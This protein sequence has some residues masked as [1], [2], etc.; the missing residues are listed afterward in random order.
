LKK[1]FPSDF[2]PPSG[3]IAIPPP[4]NAPRYNVAA[5]LNYCKEHKKILKELTLEERKPFLLPKEWRRIRLKENQKVVQL[6]YGWSL[7]LHE[8]CIVYSEHQSETNQFIIL[9]WDK[10]V[11]LTFE[12]EEDIFKVFQSSWPIEYEVNA[13]KRVIT[14]YHE[15]ELDDDED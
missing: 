1:A 13:K 6:L 4:P 5:L 12:V 15:P 7:I 3:I 2:E 8:S 11:M 9:D 14:I 10:D